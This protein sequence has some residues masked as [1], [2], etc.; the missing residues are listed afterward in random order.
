[1]R[2]TLFFGF[3][4][5]AISLQAEQNLTQ[6]LKSC[7]ENNRDSCEKAISLLENECRQDLKKCGD[8]GVIY[9]SEYGGRKANYSTAM[10]YFEKACLSG[11]A[12]ACANMGL[13][14]ESGNYRG[15]K[16]YEKARSAYEKYCSGGSAIGC[17]NLGVL[18]Y[19][20]LGCE[21]NTK[22]AIKYFEISCKAGNETACRNLKNSKQ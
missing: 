10:D 20:G 16:N 2:K 8:L 17:T 22:L 19:H 21:K 3:L 5:F 6:L 7:Q 1:M 11:N 14:Y 9:A 12:I 13:L 15:R 18:Y 4:F